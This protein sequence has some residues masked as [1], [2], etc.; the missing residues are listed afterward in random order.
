MTPSY[1]VLR[2]GSRPNVEIEIKKS[3]FVGYAARIE[4]E[5]QAREFLAEVRAEHRQARHVC[6]AFVLGPLRDVQR[7][8]DDGEPAGTAGMPILKAI[9]GR[10]TSP[11]LTEL[12]DV[13]VAVVRYF[14][15]IKLGAGGLVRAYSDTAAAT[16][17]A[18]R[19]VT[20][21]RMQ[22]FSLAVPL[23]EAGRL[24]TSLRAQGVHME[25]TDYA[26]TD[27]A[28]LNLAVPDAEDEFARLQGLLAGSGTLQPIETRW[29]DVAWA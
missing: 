4:T 28:T 18:A 10:Q 26:G 1:Q 13:A 12:S 2:A 14:G 29:V 27:V 20:R 3:R 19:L 21:Q 11:G 7:T 6:H 8:S 16:L 25:A 15:G 23:A 24:E 22:L 17:D 5:E 9:I